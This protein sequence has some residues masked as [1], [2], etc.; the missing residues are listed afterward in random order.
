MVRF[1]AKPRQRPSRGPGLPE[2]NAAAVQYLAGLGIT[3]SRYVTR[4]WL[5]TPP[6]WRAEMIFGVFNFGVA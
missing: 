3:A 5:G 2:G 4:M 1:R 6:A